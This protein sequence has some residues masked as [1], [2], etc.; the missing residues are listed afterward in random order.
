MHPKTWF[1]SLNQIFQFKFLFRCRCSV[2][3]WV[4]F[5][6][7]FT[8]SNNANKIILYWNFLAHCKKGFHEKSK[9]LLLLHSTIIMMWSSLKSW[10][11]VLITWTSRVGHIML[12]EFP[13]CRIT[14]L[15]LFVWNICVPLRQIA[16]LFFWLYFAL[17][18]WQF[19]FWQSCYCM[20]LAFMYLWNILRYS[21]LTRKVFVFLIV[22]DV[23]CAYVSKWFGGSGEHATE[24][25]C[26]LPPLW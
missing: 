13:R 8:T 1:F 26:T 16:H 3:N 14:F 10:N 20:S 25:L 23:S 11:D 22:V 7:L 2:K 15:F 21:N 9:N 5:E 12:S 18:S 6:L 17:F 19:V 4:L 24:L